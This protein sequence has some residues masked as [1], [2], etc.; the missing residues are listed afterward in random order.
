M[1]NKKE[2]FS[3][4]KRYRYMRRS[5]GDIVVFNMSNELR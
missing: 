2:S 5:L 4:K 1:V 3:E